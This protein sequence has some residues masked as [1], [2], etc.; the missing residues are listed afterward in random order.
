MDFVLIEKQINEIKYRL[1]TAC[2]FLLKKYDVRLNLK[3]GLFYTVPSLF[4]LY[5][6]S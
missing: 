6:H 5:L 3:F 1:L 4:L 2:A